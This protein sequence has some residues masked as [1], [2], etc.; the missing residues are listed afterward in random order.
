[1]KMLPRRNKPGENGGSDGRTARD[2]GLPVTATALRGP[3]VRP[4]VKIEAP[5]WAQLLAYAQEC[6]AEISGLADVRVDDKHQLVVTNP[7]IMPQAVSSVSTEITA[8]SLA[9]YVES[10]IEKGRDLSSRLCL[11][12]SHYQMQPFLSSTDKSTIADLLGYSPWWLVLVINARGEVRAFVAV[13]APFP[14]LVE[15]EVEVCPS[16]AEAEAAR[17]EIAQKVTRGRQYYSGT[18][19]CSYHGRQDGDTT[20]RNGG[21]HGDA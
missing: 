4:V 17:A 1:M 9:D 7:D 19:G 18:Y 8:A 6:P 12:H 11:W 10:C 16:A 5:C 20:G 13:S 15:V 14:L 2:G 21:S 3:S